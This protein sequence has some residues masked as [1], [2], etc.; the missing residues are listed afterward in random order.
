[1]EK[2]EGGPVGGDGSPTGTMPKIITDIKG[3]NSRNPLVGTSPLEN[4]GVE[5]R[6]STPGEWTKTIFA[7]N[8]SLR[9][10][11]HFLIRHFLPFSGIQHPGTWTLCLRNSQRSGS[12]IWTV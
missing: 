7:Q 9:V 11:Q 5:T 12:A 1:L 3:L 10:L 4:P 8:L 2:L 6:I